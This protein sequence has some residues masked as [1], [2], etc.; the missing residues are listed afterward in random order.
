[1]LGLALKEHAWYWWYDDVDEA[2]H[3]LC[4]VVI[5]KLCGDLEWRPGGGLHQQ[6]L[7]FHFQN[8][9]QE[10]VED[11]QKKSGLC[12]IETMIELGRADP[13]WWAT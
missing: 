5:L 3:V 8:V 1:M 10:P 9:L 12:L 11:F 4:V 2:L 7:L 6:E 13:A